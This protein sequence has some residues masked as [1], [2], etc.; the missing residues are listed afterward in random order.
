MGVCNLCGQHGDDRIV[1]D[2]GAP[3][4]D[5]AVRVEH[6]AIRG[7]VAPGEPRFPRIALVRVLGIGVSHG[8]FLTGDAPHEPGVA[9]EQCVQT[10]EHPAPVCVLRPPPG[11]EGT[12][13]HA[14]D[15]VTNHVRLHGSLLLESRAASAFLPAPDAWAGTGSRAHR[16]SPAGSWRRQQPAPM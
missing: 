6:D 13:V 3:P 1:A 12:A 16:R 11:Y 14:R 4:G 9:A 5:L 15:H 2:I 10:V 7:R 8:V